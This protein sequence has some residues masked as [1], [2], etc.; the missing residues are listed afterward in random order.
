MEPRNA[1]RSIPSIRANQA[2]LALMKDLRHASIGQ[3]IGMFIAWVAIVATNPTPINRVSRC[4]N[5][6]I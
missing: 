2:F 5:Q 4:A 3:H 1:H 6:V